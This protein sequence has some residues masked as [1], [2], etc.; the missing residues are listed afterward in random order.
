MSEDRPT[1]GFCLWCGKAFENVRQV[2]AHNAQ[3]LKACSVFQKLK[4]TESN[5]PV[6]D[7]M[8]ALLDREEAQTRPADIPSG[9][10]RKKKR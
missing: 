10:A 2:K 5:P 8:F 1:I 9:T 3:E 6:L 7:A 4:N